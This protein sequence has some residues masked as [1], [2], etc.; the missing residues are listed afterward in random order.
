M[1][2]KYNSILNLLLFVI[3]VSGCAISEVA[4]DVVERP[5]PSSP[6]IVVKNDSLS[7]LKINSII[8]SSH[9]YILVNSIIQSGDKREL[10]ISPEDAKEL[11]IPQEKYH[12]FVINLSISQNS[13]QNP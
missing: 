4:V 3:L 2:L 6:T 10:C 9:E 11:S 13:T 5:L 7:L 8:Q 1:K 12:E